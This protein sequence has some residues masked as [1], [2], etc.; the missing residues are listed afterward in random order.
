VLSTPEDM[1][2]YMRFYL[3]GGKTDGGKQ[4]ISTAAFTA[5]TVAA[6]YNNGKPAGSASPVLAEAPAFYRRY[7][8]GLSV[9]DARGD[10]VI[11]HTGGVSGY[12]ACMQMNLT[13]GFGVVAMANLVEAPLHPCAIVLYAMDVLRAQSAGEPLPPAPTPPDPAR[14]ADASAYSGTYAMHGGGALSVVA[15]GDRLFLV[16]GGDRIALYP[17]GPDVFWADDARFA[18]FL[19]AFGRDRNKTVVELTYGSQWYPNERYRG[20]HAFPHPAAWD[21]FVGRY[22]NT[23]LGQPE[24]T[25][26]VIVKD[27]LTFDGLDPLEPLADGTFRLGT[28]VVRFDAYAGAQPQ[29]VS[30]DDE[31]LYRVTLP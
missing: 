16:D 26:V 21:Q 22:E 31:R 2:R 18:T 20:P 4:L 15:D 1:A 14:V 19:I 8:L 11:G 7:G 28:S 5:M 29:R 27:A 10:H 17:R 12:T 25:R 13:R 9:F 23:F 6:S 30:I 24:V 3:N